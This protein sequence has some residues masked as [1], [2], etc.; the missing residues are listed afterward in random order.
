MA[1]TTPTPTYACVLVDRPWP[2][3]FNAGIDALV[4]KF[5][6][7]AEAVLVEYDRLSAV[8]HYASKYE[9]HND[10]CPDHNPLNHVFYE[11]GPKFAKLVETYVQT[12][13]VLHTLVVAAGYPCDGKQ[14]GNFARQSSV[15]EAKCYYRPA[16]SFVNDYMKTPFV[17][18]LSG[19]DVKGVKKSGGTADPGVDFGSLTASG[20][21][22]RLSELLATHENRLRRAVISYSKFCQAED[23]AVATGLV[24]ATGQRDDHAEEVIK[25][26]RYIDEWFLQCAMVYRDQ[27]HPDAPREGSACV[28]GLTAANLDDRL[29][30][31]PK[32]VAWLADHPFLVWERAHAQGQAQDPPRKKAKRDE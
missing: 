16:W 9:N 2:D 20:A 22:R 23:R 24:C 4:T 5:N 3:A 8:A 21:D 11:E 31:D 1:T 6:E 19:R 15:D 29:A 30:A 26:L 27:G 7:A 10:C 25:V 32:C 17:E 18:T 14:R 12:C 13:T 28:A